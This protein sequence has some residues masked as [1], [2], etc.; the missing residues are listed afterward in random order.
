M[1]VTWRTALLEALQGHV[2]FPELDLINQSI[3]PL[4]LFQGSCLLSKFDQICH[5]HYRRQRNRFLSGWMQLPV[6]ILE[7]SEIA[8]PKMHVHL[9]QLDQEQ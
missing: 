7:S 2:F 1:Q 6:D 4:D 8:K 5:A 9:V 3:G